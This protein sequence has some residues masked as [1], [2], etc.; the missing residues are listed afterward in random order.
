[1]AKESQAARTFR[2][3]LAELMKL[4]GITIT[5]LAESTGMSRPGLSRILSGDEG[6]SLSRA[7]RIA[8][9]LGFE[10]VD[11]LDSEKVLE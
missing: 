9:E 5:E 1:M 4:R 8:E 10:L 6:V 2:E 7:E 3:R 11:L